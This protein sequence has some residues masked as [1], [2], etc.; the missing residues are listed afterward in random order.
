MRL[1]PDEGW[2]IREG[3]LVIC[4]DPKYTGDYNFQDRP[5]QFELVHGDVYVVCRMYGDL[6]A[7][8]AKVTLDSPVELSGKIRNT[9]KGF[10]SLGFLPLCAVTL[11]AN[12]SS[13][14]RRCAEYDKSS[15]GGPQTPGNSAEDDNKSSRGGPQTP[16]NGLAVTPPYRTHSI[17]ASR[18]IFGRYHPEQLELPGVVFELCG[19]CSVDEDAKES[20]MGSVGK[21]R[22][23]RLGRRMTLKKPWHRAT[24]S[25]PS[26]PQEPT[27]RPP[28]L[29]ISDPATRAQLGSTAEA[30]RT[31]R[32][33]NQVRRA[34]DNLGEALQAHF[35]SSA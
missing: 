31:K 34:M 1:G 9:P 22:S 8:C 16:G 10:Q 29:H 15:L 11:A 7:L 35:G 26:A 5:H 33:R 20:K 32:L 23:W 3:S 14:M 27:G 12:F 4:L 18:D 30:A 19:G 25:D 13:F 6:W 2:V 17:P 28:S 24:K 21:S